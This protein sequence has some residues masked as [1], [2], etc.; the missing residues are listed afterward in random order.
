MSFLKL[1][2]RCTCYCLLFGSCIIHVGDISFYFKIR[3]GHSKG[4]RKDKGIKN[5]INEKL[6]SYGSCD[7]FTSKN[8]LNCIWCINQFKKFLSPDSA[9]RCPMLPMKL[10]SVKT[11]KAEN[12]LTEVTIRR[13]RLSDHSRVPPQWL[14]KGN[15]WCHF[16]MSSVF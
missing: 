1:K 15:K 6:S 4:F 2:S 10:I 8:V 13:L 16:M 3:N 12:Y 14:I 5:C 11:S 7:S 9:I